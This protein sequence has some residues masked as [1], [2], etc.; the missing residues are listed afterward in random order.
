MSKS[1]PDTAPFIVVKADDQGNPPHFTLFQSRKQAI[2]YAT[3]RAFYE[4]AV[5]RVFR[6]ERIAS[7][8]PQHPQLY[9][10]DREISASEHR[11]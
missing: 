11:S 4:C 7:A 2:E 6:A 1:H 3:S 9:E 8:H 10:E 5:Y